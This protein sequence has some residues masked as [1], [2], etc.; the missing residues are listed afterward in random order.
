[1]VSLSW[2][3]IFCPLDQLMHRPMDAF[4]RNNVHYLAWSSTYRDYLIEHG[5]DACNITIVFTLS[6]IRSTLLSILSIQTRSCP[7]AQS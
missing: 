4:A 5:V 6:V 3:Q 7:E 2:E 1:V